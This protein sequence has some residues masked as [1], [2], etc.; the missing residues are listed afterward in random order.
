MTGSAKP[1]D[2]PAIVEKF[3]IEGLYGYRTIGLTSSHAA[4]ILIA[5]NG[6]GKTT[7]LAAL[8][9]F[10]RA[11][12][13]RLSNLQFDRIICKL[14][15]ISEPLCV[16]Q[17]DVQSLS[18]IAEGSELWM[19]ANRY[20][21]HPTELMEFL[22]LDF[23]KKRRN[24]RLLQDTEPFNKI[25]AQFSYDWPETIQFCER[26]S[27]QLPAGTDNIKMVRKKLIETFA[28]TDIV[29]LPT[30]RRLEIPLSEKKAG[31]NSSMEARLGLPKRGL[32]ATDIQFGLTDIS[33]RLSDLNNQL[34]Q[35][36]N[37]GYRSFSANIINELIGGTWDSA[38]S[39]N[40]SAPDK[41][42]LNL[43]FSRL[44]NAPTVP[45]FKVNIPDIDRIYDPVTKSEQAGKFLQYFLVKLNSVIKATHDIE[46]QVRDF[47]EVC[48]SYLS[49]QD[50]A[51][52]ADM[53][54]PND[55]KAL[56]L[57]RTNLRV[58]VQR[59]LTGQN[60]PMNYLSSGE[61]QMISLF[62]KLYLYTRPKII[63]I[64]EPELS[65]S[66]SWQSR[67][68]PDILNAPSCAQLLAITHS[69]FVFDN[70]LDPYARALEFSIAQDMSARISDEDAS[71]EEEHPHE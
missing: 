23:P 54:I 67:I 11:Q 8:D 5:G 61:K 7:L 40:E 36:S 16:T 1:A 39:K 66:I 58:G 6:S 31:R 24:P 9:A 60:V 33:E 26:A 51:G 46:K 2:R 41:E 19:L 29:Y 38:E 25:Y 70:E 34:L 62:A 20:S 15:D 63:L 3:V 37:E 48:N 59:V 17:S 57:D 52:S 30:Y 27:A 69:P 53:F 44:K 18:V 14:R 12:F 42:S 50:T 13:T 4:C 35:K 56:V 55:E 28:G 68:L 49:R 43:F 10:L 22:E 47:V 71:L 65:L 64:D 32:Y 45:H 21:L